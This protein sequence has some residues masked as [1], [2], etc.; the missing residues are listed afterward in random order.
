MTTHYIVGGHG[1]DYGLLQGNDTSHR[2]WPTIAQNTVWETENPGSTISQIQACYYGGQVL[3]NGKVYGWGYNSHPN[4][5]NGNSSDQYIPVKPTNVPHT[6]VKIANAFYSRYGIASNGELWGW[7]YN[8][9]GQ[10][11]LGTTTHSNAG[12]RVKLN[13][14]TYMSGVTDVVGGV[15][16]TIIYANG[17][18]YG[19]GYSGYGNNTTDGNTG[20]DTYPV[21]WSNQFNVSGTQINP[22]SFYTLENN[23]E[24][25]TSTF[26][27]DK[28]NGNMQIV[29]E[30]YTTHIL[31]ADGKLYG[32]GYNSHGEIGIGNTSS[33]N[34]P[35]SI[36]SS[37]FNNKQIIKI[38]RVCYY[39]SCA[40]TDEGEVYAW[41]NGGY[42]A[43]LKGNT[44]N[45]YTPQLLT[46]F[47]NNNIKIV[48]VTGG[49]YHWLALSDQGKIYTWGY[50]SH[51]QRGNGNTTGQN[52][53]TTPFE[54]S[55]F[56]NSNNELYGKEVIFIKARE[57]HCMAVTS[58]NELYTWVII[59]NRY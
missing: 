25:Y 12:N 37:Y 7:G 23:E 36:A 47:S 4:L 29:N 40:L 19:L 27:Y 15:H 55:D 53:S 6:I 59:P 16:H 26:N 5:G 13:S 17:Q 58:D 30:H 10:M 54:L 43:F 35:R 39:A 51:G 28:Y 14:S 46:W 21:L 9:H 20:Q 22:E 32:W 48:D 11:G 3:V 31:T 44:S 41:G 45:Y 56:N 57:Y 38:C 2:Y 33:Y 42:G 8:G 1:S 52:N 50:N 49:H 34:Y 24:T 18:L